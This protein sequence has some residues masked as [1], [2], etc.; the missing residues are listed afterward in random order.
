MDEK[1]NGNSVRTILKSKHPDAEPVHLE[2]VIP[3]LP[4]TPPHPVRFESITRETIRR[5]A[6][7]TY[8]AAGPSGVDADIWWRMC[9]TFADASDELCDAMA[10]CA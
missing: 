4:P 6:L 3:G 5:A 9:T 10:G 8:G 7:N 1:I 2:A